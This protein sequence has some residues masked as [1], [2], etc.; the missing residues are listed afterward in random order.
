[1]ITFVEDSSTPPK[2]LSAY[3]FIDS[4]QKWVSV[5][6]PSVP[7]FTASELK[8]ITWNLDARSYLVKQ[9]FTQAMRF[10]QNKV[11]GDTIRTPCCILLQEVHKDVFPALLQSG[12]IRQNFVL[13]PI[14]T[15]DWITPYGIVTLISKTMPVTTVFAV[16][17]HMTTVGRQAL[18]L[19]IHLSAP[20][21]ETQEEQPDKRIRTIRIANTHLEPDPSGSRAR[22]KQLKQIA[23]MLNVPNLDACICAGSMWSVQNS[24]ATAPFE[25]G[26]SDACKSPKRDSMTW[27]Y[28]PPTEQPPARLDKILYFPTERVEV[29][30]PARIAHRARMLSGGYISDHCGLSTMVKI[31]RKH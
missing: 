9:R 19:D 16:E 25:A 27:G 31:L 10:L 24:D 26:F 11:L 14:S 21:P 12:W 17:L 15:D 13:A 4:Q 7:D 1:M 28:Q 18:F 5:D 8:L 6:S 2:I 22:P 3:R 29:G 20:P 23:R 30:Y